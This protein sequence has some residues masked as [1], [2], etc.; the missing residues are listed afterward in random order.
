MAKANEK[1]TATPWRAFHN[2]DRSIAIEQHGQANPI[3]EVHLQRHHNGIG[4]GDLSRAVS[5]LS[6]AIAKAEGKLE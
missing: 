5:L 2:I 6:E 4:W 1:H 3:L